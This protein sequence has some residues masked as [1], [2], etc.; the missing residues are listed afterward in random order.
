[1][2]ILRVAN[3]L[4]RNVPAPVPRLVTETVR[5]IERVGEEKTEFVRVRF[6][7]A[8]RR[9]PREIR[10]EPEVLRRPNIE[11]TTGVMLAEPWRCN[12]V[13]DVADRLAGCEFRADDFCLPAYA[14]ETGKGNECDAVS[15]GV[16]MHPPPG[17]GRAW[18]EPQ[19]PAVGISSDAPELPRLAL[20][21][22][23]TLV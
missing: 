6:Q 8:K 11:G 18:R 2:N 17:S 3:G 4:A 21:W 10:I 14:A 12:V 23:T 9:R 5:V 20:E 16:G 19:H 1:L 13:Q 15:R 22:Q 7:P